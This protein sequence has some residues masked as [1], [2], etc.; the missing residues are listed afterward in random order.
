MRLICLMGP[1]TMRPTGPI[2]PGHMDR[3][4]SDRQADKQRDSWTTCQTVKQM[5]G[6]GRLLTRTD[7]QMSRPSN[8]RSHGE[9]EGQTIRHSVGHSDSRMDGRT[10]GQRARWTKGYSDRQAGGQADEGK[11][12]WTDEQ[13]DRL[14]HSRS[15]DRRT[16]RGHQQTCKA[17]LLR[18][19]TRLKI[20][21]G[22]IAVL[23]SILK[24]TD[25]EKKFVQMEKLAVLH[26]QDPC[27]KKSF[28]TFSQDSLKQKVSHLQTSLSQDLMHDTFKDLF[29]DAPPFCSE[30]ID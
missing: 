2:V 20:L 22:D 3:R 13:T 12:R 18:M 26:C 8:K 15:H 30:S 25:C 17:Q 24:M 27:T 23:T 14:R 4:V 16:F 7:S 29:Q 5:D 11:D 9:M 19:N 6:P 1:G 28:V 10:G 21:Q